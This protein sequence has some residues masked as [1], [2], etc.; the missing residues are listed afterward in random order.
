MSLVACTSGGGDVSIDVTH[1][2]C[3]P[4]TISSPSA[5]ASQLTGI[6]DAFTMWRR[7]GVHT[8]ER[9]AVGMIEIR[10]EPASGLFFGVYDDEHS[11]I[12]INQAI[13]DPDKLSVV[14]AHELGHSF[15]LDH[16]SGRASLM[17]PG[18]TSVLPTTADDAEVQRL[19]GPCAP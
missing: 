14:I 2:V 7:H 19:W 15:G 3:T 13:T 11:V 18:N 16:I 10:F 6:D 4:I 12:Y 9:A 1:D 5:T 8:L 17:N